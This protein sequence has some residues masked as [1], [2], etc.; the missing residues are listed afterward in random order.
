MLAGFFFISE[1]KANPNEFTFF[2]L[3]KFF[4]FIPPG[5]KALLILR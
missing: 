2:K 4:L 3:F 5:I 1:N